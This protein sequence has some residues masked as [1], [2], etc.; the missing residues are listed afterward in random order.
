VLFL[1]W[2]WNWLVIHLHLPVSWTFL[3]ASEEPLSST[4][5]KYEEAT[6]TK[7]EEPV[8][9]RDEEAIP[10][11]DEGATPTKA[12][13]PAPSMDEE[14]TPTK[15]E[16]PAPSRDEE[17]PPVKPEEPTPKP[18]VEPDI[19]LPKIPPEVPGKK[20]PD[21]ASP[22]DVYIHNAASRYLMLDDPYLAADELY[23]S[24]FTGY[25][26]DGIFDELERLNPPFA[27]RVFALAQKF[28]DHPLVGIKKIFGADKDACKAE[29]AKIVAMDMSQ[30]VVLRILSRSFSTGRHDLVDMTMKILAERKASTPDEVTQY[31]RDLSEMQKYAK[32]FSA[33]DA[34]G[35]L[36]GEMPMTVDGHLDFDVALLIKHLPPPAAATLFKLCKHTYTDHAVPEYPNNWT[37]LGMPPEEIAECL[38]V[39]LGEQEIERFPFLWHTNELLI[40]IAPQI[41]QDVREK[42]LDTAN[43]PSEYASVFET[44]SPEARAKYAPQ[45]GAEA[46][47]FA[48]THKPGHPG[49]Q[50][51]L[52]KASME[53]IEAYL[54][55]AGIVNLWNLLIVMLTD[56]DTKRG[57]P[58][59]AIKAAYVVRYFADKNILQMERMQKFVE[60][61]HKAWSL[62]PAVT[63]ILPPP[64]NELSREKRWEPF[65]Y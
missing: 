11:M 13:E 59:F 10:S 44:L 23:W 62:P 60:W 47:A 15:A 29:L 52:A 33:F 19:E 5:I 55:S 32:V 9:S 43:V 14:T 27:D 36:I 63:R 53:E 61:V 45:T 34:N 40:K 8:P 28:S 17:T 37:L 22:Y 1:K 46:V 18:D 64:L 3:I 31:E 4:P 41:P 16:E 50:V 2:V 21:N 56:V 65:R 57:L 49:M 38:S 26:C 30:G 20:L 35:R 24:V 58:E 6:P 39:E 54:A 48:A 42:F 7:A 51:W 25:S 12:E